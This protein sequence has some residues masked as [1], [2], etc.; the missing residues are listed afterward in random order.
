MN[1]I[2]LLIC[3]CLLISGLIACKPKKDAGTTTSDK[4]TQS[5]VLVEDFEK[6]RDSAPVNLETLDLHENTLIMQISYSG[7]CEDHEFSLLGLKYT[8]GS[9]PVA[10][11]IQLYHNNNGDH[12]RELLEKKLRIDISAFALKNSE[13]VMLKIKGWK[14]P[15]LYTLAK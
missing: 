5:G 8:S 1:R 6:Y 10:R 15:V 9:N 7:G 12:C 3:S 2:L 14:N 4:V 11:E 13:P